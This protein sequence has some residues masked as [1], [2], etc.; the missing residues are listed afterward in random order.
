MAVNELNLPRAFPQKIAK[1]E[2]AHPHAYIET[3]NTNPSAMDVLRQFQANI[4]TLEDLNGRLR[5]IMAEIRD[6]VRK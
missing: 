6:L 2:K 1:Q 3:P 4:S 5:F